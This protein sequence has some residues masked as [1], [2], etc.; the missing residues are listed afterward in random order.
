MESVRIKKC[1]VIVRMCILIGR[2]KMAAK[3]CAKLTQCEVG[4]DTSF[5]THSLQFH[6]Q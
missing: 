4:M 2:I 1:V 6:M 5:I 3:M